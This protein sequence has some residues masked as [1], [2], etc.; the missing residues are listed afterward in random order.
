MYECHFSSFLQLSSE[1][2]PPFI[3]RDL[4]FFPLGARDP[5]VRRRHTDWRFF[6]GARAARAPPG[7]RDP[8]GTPQGPPRDP[9]GT[10][11]GPPGTPK[12]NKFSGGC[13]PQPRVRLVLVSFLVLVSLVL[14]I[15]VWCMAVPGVKKLSVGQ[16]GV[17]QF[18]VWERRGGRW[19]GEG[20]KRGGGGKG[21]GYHRA[22]RQKMFRWSVWCWSVF[23]VHGG[24][25]RR[26][27]FRW[28]NWCRSLA[29]CASRRQ[30]SINKFAFCF[31]VCSRLRTG[32]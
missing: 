5:P 16:V 12:I 7:A 30:A 1:L 27:M 11:Q 4:G 13:A 20:G 32:C 3:A 18:W 14:V 10:P 25:W 31:N 17:G 15:F 8:P 9:P 22:R 29:W 28:S 26:K 24:A 23:L 2:P 6:L 19:E 21:E